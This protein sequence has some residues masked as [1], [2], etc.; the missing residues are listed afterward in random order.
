MRR[1]TRQTQKFLSIFNNILFYDIFFDVFFSM[2]I[3]LLLIQKKNRKKW[4]K[5]FSNINIILNSF[6]S[7]HLQ[8]NHYAYSRLLKL[9][10]T[11]F[12]IGYPGMAAAESVEY[13]REERREGS[14]RGDHLISRHLD[15]PTSRHV[16]SRH[17]V[18]RQLVSAT[19]SPRLLF[20][21]LVVFC[22]LVVD[23]TREPGSLALLKALSA[24][25]KLSSSNLLSA[26]SSSASTGLSSSNLRTHNRHDTLKSSINLEQPHF[27]KFRLFSFLILVIVFHTPTFLSQKLKCRSGDLQIWN[28]INKSNFS[29]FK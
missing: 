26:T 21:A 12:L 22:S 28:V 3:C 16:T 19:H 5:S 18:S 11:N 27:Q 6:P 24:R 29:H 7:F 20:T 23:E 15:T 25:L 8:F 17:V 10:L 4:I 2:I 1:A 9:V 13:K 14:K